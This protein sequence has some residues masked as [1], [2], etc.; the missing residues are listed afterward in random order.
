MKFTVFLFSLL[1][2]LMTAVIFRI[3][4]GPTTVAWKFETIN[5]SLREIPYDPRTTLDQKET[6][7]F[8]WIRFNRCDIIYWVGAQSTLNEK[9]QAA[10]Y[11][12]LLLKSI[13]NSLPA[14]NNLYITRKMGNSET[15]TFG[16]ILYSLTDK[17]P[18]LYKVQELNNIRQV[19]IN[20][21]EINDKHSFVLND[22]FGVTVFHPTFTN[23]IKILTANLF[24]KYIINI[25]RNKD[26]TFSPVITLLGYWKD[27]DAEKKEFEKK[28]KNTA[29]T[30]SITS[31]SPAT[32]SAD[33]E[34]IK[35]ENVSITVFNSLTTKNKS[36]P[37]NKRKISTT[38]AYVLRDWDNAEIIV[39]LGKKANFLFW[40]DALSAAEVDFFK[41]SKE[42]QQ[43]RI[44]IIWEGTLPLPTHFVI[45]FVEELE[46]GLRIFS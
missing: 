17:I 32:N 7:I 1:F 10:T 35:D 15:E 44:T 38:E 3:P 36:I 26:E 37:F 23:D 46:K 12:G 27:F 9:E 2:T 14:L 33:Y 41:M 43:T 21:K 5:Y 30:D 28:I 22:R 39:F 18:R 34:N 13:R 31:S 42:N 29:A 11:V 20:L 4:S 25:E 19:P 45:L 16:S 24:A 40:T 6:Y 8:L